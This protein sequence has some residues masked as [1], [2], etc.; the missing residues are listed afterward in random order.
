V[1]HGDKNIKGHGKSVS[2]FKEGKDET[3]LAGQYQQANNKINAWKISLQAG[4]GNLINKLVHNISCQCL[5]LLN[6]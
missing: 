1:F 3:V 5:G 2:L 4:Q 6:S